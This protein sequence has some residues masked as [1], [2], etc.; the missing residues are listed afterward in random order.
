SAPADQSA[1]DPTTNI[2]WSEV[3]QGNGLGFVSEPLTEDLVAL[4]PAA[5]QIRLSSSAADT[6]LGLTLSEVRPDGQEMLISTGVQRASV[7]STDKAQSSPTVPFFTH[8]RKEP[9]NGSTVTVPVQI[10]PL[11]HVFRAGSRIR[12]DIHAV[13]GDAERWAYESVDPAGGST[14]NTVH[15][16]GAQPSSLTMT[17]AP[18]RG[19][20]RTLE[21]CPSTGRPC[22]TWIPA[23]NG[24]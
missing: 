2:V 14:L 3:P 9:L 6:D 13:G 4:G 17:L 8:D 1:T 15:L 18:Q 20:P 5:A 21:A 11:G 16:G 22:R 7:R 19:Y 12:I 23:A 10:L 24:G